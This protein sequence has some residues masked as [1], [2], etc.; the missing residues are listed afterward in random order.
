MAQTW[1][2]VSELRQKAGDSPLP[3]K[4]YFWAFVEDALT[5]VAVHRWNNFYKDVI[6]ISDAFYPLIMKR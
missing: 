2:K 6:G 5:P 4:E 3:K 1:D